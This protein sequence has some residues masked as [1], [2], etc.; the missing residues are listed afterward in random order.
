MGHAVSRDD[1]VHCYDRSA[2]DDLMQG[3]DRSARNHLLQSS[4]RSARD[5]AGT[6][7]PNLV[8]EAKSTGETMVWTE[9]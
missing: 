6:R 8:T 2:L 7:N 1:V 4:E 9:L 5:D 3:R